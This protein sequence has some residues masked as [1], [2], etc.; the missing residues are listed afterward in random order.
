MK[1]WWF[2]DEETP[3]SLDIWIPPE[4]SSFKKWEAGYAF[5]PGYNQCHPHK[6][7]AISDDKEEKD[8]YKIKLN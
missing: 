4:A 5:Y 8:K 7:E 6:C 3:L 1:L 2:R